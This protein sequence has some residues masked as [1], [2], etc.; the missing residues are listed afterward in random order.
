MGLIAPTASVYKKFP[1]Q[2]VQNRRT[3]KLRLTTT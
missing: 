3:L 2:K 1:L